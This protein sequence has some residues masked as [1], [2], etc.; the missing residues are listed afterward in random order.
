MNLDPTGSP[1]HEQTVAVALIFIIAQY[2]VQQLEKQNQ[3]IDSNQAIDCDYGGPG[4][5]R[6]ADQRFR[7]PLLYPTELRGRDIGSLS[8]GNLS[9]LGAGEG[10]HG[11]CVANASMRDVTFSPVFSWSRLA[12]DFRRMVADS[13]GSRSK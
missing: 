5:S 11:S 12:E 7:K 8:H 1:R 3:P 10:G 9:Q 4:R 2:S 6:T 13:P